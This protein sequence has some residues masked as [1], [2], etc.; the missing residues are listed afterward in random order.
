MQ[1][2]DDCI[3]SVIS[4]TVAI[5]SFEAA[6]NAAS[7]I[8]GIIAAA[9]TAVATLFKTIFGVHEARLEESIKEHQRQVKKLEAEYN[10]LSD[11]IS[12]AFS[13]FQLGANTQEA[14]QNLEKQNR[15]YR[16]MIENEK[17]K[18]DT[19]ED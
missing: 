2:F 5:V 13:G 9:L 7:G 15:Q 1:G 8:I 12:N 10:N 17:E 11:A 16:A 3:Q 4:L 18:K 14:I 19:D 6:A